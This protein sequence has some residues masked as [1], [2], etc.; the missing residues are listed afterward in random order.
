MHPPDHCLPSPANDNKMSEQGEAEQ[1]I[2]L[3]TPAG[4]S[5]GWI[6]FPSYVNL[7]VPVH[8]GI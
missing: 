6:R 5:S 1:D 7:K 2:T 3:R 4:V 8:P